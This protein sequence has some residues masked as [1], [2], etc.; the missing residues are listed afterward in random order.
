MIREDRFLMSRKQYAADLSS[1]TIESRTGYEDREYFHGV[2]RAVWFRRKRRGGWSPS[3][4][5]VTV[6][7]VGSLWCSLDSRPLDGREFLERHHDGRY[8]GRCAGRW[9]GTGYWGAEDLDVQAEHLAVLKPM[10]A[11][12]EQDPKAPALPETFDGWWRF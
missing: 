2:I 8:G 5:I 11:A 6:A 4:G 12:Y 9:D 10:L 7:C 1:L 3:S